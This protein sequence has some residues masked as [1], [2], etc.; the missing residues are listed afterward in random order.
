MRLSFT[1]TQSDCVFSTVLLIQHIFICWPVPSSAP[2]FSAETENTQYYQCSFIYSSC[3]Y[4]NTAFICYK[5]VLCTLSQVCLFTCCW[6]C[7]VQTESTSLLIDRVKAPHSYYKTCKQTKTSSVL[8]G[9]DPLCRQIRWN[10]WGTCLSLDLRKE[11]VL[12]QAFISHYSICP[13]TH[14][15]EKT[16][17]TAAQGR[18]FHTKWFLSTPWWLW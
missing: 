1:W 16:D 18:S 8:W 9:F 13:T 5:H 10:L 4:F 14:C 3:L 12:L 11:V 17:L 7:S 15:K 6:I 2:L